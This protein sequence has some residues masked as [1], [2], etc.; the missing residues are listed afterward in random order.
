MERLSNV[1]VSRMLLIAC[2]AAYAV[3]MMVKMCVPTVISSM[4]DENFLTKSQS[5]LLSGIFY[6]TYGLGQLIFGGYFNNHTPFIGIKLA[7]LGSALCCILMSL[8][9]NFY[10]LILIW[11]ACALF[12]ACF[13]PALMKISSFILCGK[14]SVWANNYMMIANQA[15]TVY[16]Y[17]SAVL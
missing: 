3:T 4:V 2:F 9:D 17:C 1:N 15:G 11:S 5:G 13:F 12:N 16:A 6:L 8:T 10:L 14:H 7:L